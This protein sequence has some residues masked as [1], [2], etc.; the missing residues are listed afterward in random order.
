[1]QALG[2][3]FVVVDALKAPISLDPAL[4]QRMADRHLGIGFDQLLLIEP[5]SEPDC[6]VRYRIF[7]ADA[8]EVSQCGNGARCVGDYLWKNGI[9]DKDT[10]VL[11]TQAR[12]LTVKRHHDKIQ[13]NM[14]V[15]LWNPT[16]I[17]FIPD[18]FD[19]P[20][21][22]AV[23]LGNPHL[24]IVVPDVD[25]APVQPLGQALQ[26][27]PAFPQQVN[28]GFMQILDRQ[29][30]RLRVYER[31]AG[32]TLACGSGACAAVVVGHQAG[33]LAEAVEVALPGGNLQIHWAGEG[34]PVWMIGGAQRIFEGI[35][36][37]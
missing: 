16:E 2:N 32:E 37:K 8:S 33:L 15:P 19:E 1:M 14:G 5:A 28:V 20:H 4:I 31:G 17:P 6:D 7:N 10:L 29:H 21:L 23:N 30:I 24:V 27:H 3:D 12:R 26:N 35:F 36:Y 13:V 18:A 9:R 11:A 25:T 34:E 22:G